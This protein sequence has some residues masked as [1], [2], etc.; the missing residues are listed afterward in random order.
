MLLLEKK[1]SLAWHIRLFLIWLP[2]ISLASFLAPRRANILNSCSALNML[3]SLLILWLCINCFLF[4]ECLF[5]HKSFSIASFKH[6]QLSS[7]LGSLLR[8]YKLITSSIQTYYAKPTA[9]YTVLQFLVY[10]F[11]L[12]QDTI[13]FLMT[14]TISYLSIFNQQAKYQAPRY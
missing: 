11:N 1:Y 7:T 13:S 6:R 12:S 3:I 10:L 5:P 4:Q 8:L 2:P 9:L 14:V